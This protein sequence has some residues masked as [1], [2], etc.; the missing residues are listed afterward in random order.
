MTQD[1]QNLRNLVL[2]KLPTVKTNVY[3]DVDGE[4]LPHKNLLAIPR[5]LLGNPNIKRTESFMAV[6]QVLQHVNKLHP[7][8]FESGA[9]ANLSSDG[10]PLCKSGSNTLRV[11]KKFVFSAYKNLNFSCFLGGFSKL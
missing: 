3:E 1:I 8:I 9:R 10:V 4:L 6:G 7:G 2:T 5:E 11:R